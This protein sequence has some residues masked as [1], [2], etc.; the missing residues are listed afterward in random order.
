MLQHSGVAE[1]CYNEAMWQT[2]TYNKEIGDEK[3]VDSQIPKEIK[4]EALRTRQ[5]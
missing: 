4:T 3:Q 5:P 1:A 2:G